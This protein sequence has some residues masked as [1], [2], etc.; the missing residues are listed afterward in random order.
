MITVELKEIIPKNCSWDDWIVKSRAD[1]LEN[2]PLH[3]FCVAFG[4][5][6]GLRRPR[7]RRPLYEER[8][9]VPGITEIASSHAA[10]M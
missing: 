2:P 10:D 9:R 4:S 5:S 8:V 6:P 7:A 1:L 3:N